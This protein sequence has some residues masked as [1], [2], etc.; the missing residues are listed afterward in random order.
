MTDLYV[1]TPQGQP[2]PS[3]TERWAAQE[4]D[5]Q[6]PITLNSAGGDPAIYAKMKA[7]A[8]RKAEAAK[9]FEEAKP[10][11]DNLPVRPVANF[12][13]Q[14]IG[15]LGYEYAPDAAFDRFGQA[16]LLLIGGNIEALRRR[17]IR[18]I[19]KART[20]VDPNGKFSSDQLQPIASPWLPDSLDR[21][22]VVQV[23]YANAGQPV[24]FMDSQGR[25]I[26][27]DYV[28]KYQEQEDWNK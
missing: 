22:T 7:E 9:L 27:R 26:G 3:P 17:D 2:V 19:G 13:L 11:I 28:E 15:D 6:G 4:A 23:M 1:S 24:V 20:N 8:K 10:Y 14:N 21:S 18:A 12:N 25:A 5:R 16:M